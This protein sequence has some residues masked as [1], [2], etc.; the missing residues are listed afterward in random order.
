LTL[1]SADKPED[2]ERF[3]RSDERLRHGDELDALVARWI[4]ARDLDDVVEGFQSARIPVTRVMDL[5]ALNEDPHVNARGSI[6][7][8][9]DPA[10]DLVLLPA[11]HPRLSK[12]RPRS[13]GSARP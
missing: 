3:G 11:P 1:I 6:V 8:M 10:M 13:N 4:R 12:A 7:G 5:E 2:R 9:V